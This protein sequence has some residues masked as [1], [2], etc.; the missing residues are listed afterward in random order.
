MRRTLALLAIVTVM[1]T[2]ATA[3]A[4][5]H[6]FW[7]RVKLDFHRNNAWPEPFVS[8]DRQLVQQPLAMYAQQGWRLQNTIGD[9]L[10]KDDSNDLTL[11]GKFK[12]TQIVTQYPLGR[13]GVYVL[14]GDSEEATAYRVK[15]VQ[16]AVAAARPT[17]GTPP[18]VVTRIV[19]RGGSGSYYHSVNSGFQKSIPAPV[20]P[21]ASGDGDN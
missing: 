8:A 21:E 16:E 4:G 6:E 2:T 15:Q 18:V 7:Q 19:P 5:W 1:S 3:H 14:R 11:A 13:R 12:V 20:L 9:E 17:R 10:F